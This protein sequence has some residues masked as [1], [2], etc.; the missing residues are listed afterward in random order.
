MCG[1]RRDRS[2]QKRARDLQDTALS[3]LAFHGTEAVHGLFNVL[4]GMRRD[5]ERRLPELLS[6]T[7]FLNAGLRTVQVRHRPLDPP[8]SREIS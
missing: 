8:L 6:T 1:H 4:F 5:N 7:P 3:G 2:A